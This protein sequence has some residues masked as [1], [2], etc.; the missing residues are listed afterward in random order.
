MFQRIIFLF[1]LFFVC[2]TF[3]HATKIVGFEPDYAGRIIQ[4]Y[5]YSDPITK[6]H[7]DIFSIHI[8]NDGNFSQN[9]TIEKTTVCYADFDVYSGI[10]VLEPEK[11]LKIKLP[12]LRTKT[13]AEEKNPYFKPARFWFHIETDSKDE[14]NSVCSRFELEYNEL[15][16]KNFNELYFRQSKT[17]L[18]S[19]SKTLQ[20]NFKEFNNPFVQNLIQFRLKILKGE[21]LRQNQDKILSSLRPADFT[22]FNPGFIDILDRIFTNKLVFETNSIGGNDLRNTINKGNLARLKEFAKEKYALQAGV[23]DLVLLKLLHDAYYSGSFSKQAILTMLGS[24]IF[25]QNTRKEIQA[26][27]T[28]VAKKIVYLTPGTK[29]PEICLPDINS[30]VICT[31][32]SDR[33]IYLMF[34]DMELQICREHLKYLPTITEKFQDKL[35]VYIVLINQRSEKIN[36]FLESNKI[37][38]NVLFDTG[39]RNTY[40]IKSYPS[41]FLLGKDQEIILNPAKSPLDGFENQY[42]EYLKRIMFRQ[43]K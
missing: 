1:S 29:A 9:V 36:E 19:V 34:M 13:F 7:Q 12:T 23:D 21:V 27:A 2:S 22:C 40:K 8:Q 24:D 11:E 17:M 25:K 28:S 10:L 3:A 14:I 5:T 4:F 20:A 15:V 33:N 38:A 43:N 16:D 37:N 18:D 32:K 31:S 30:K 42:R 6:K 39:F 35:E 41:C 26:F